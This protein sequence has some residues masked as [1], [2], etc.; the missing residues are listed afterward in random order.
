MTKSKKIIC[1]ILAGLIA[2]SAVTGTLFYI[3]NRYSKTDFAV[4]TLPANPDNYVD[5]RNDVHIASNPSDIQKNYDTVSVNNG[6]YTI[7]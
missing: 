2:V 3:F 5:F 4:L 6:E 1:I 7:V